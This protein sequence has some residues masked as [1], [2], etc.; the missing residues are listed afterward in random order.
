M[1]KKGVKMQEKNVQGKKKQEK[2]VQ[3]NRSQENRIQGKRVQEGKKQGSP[4]RENKRPESRAVKGVKPE[5][6]QRSEQKQRTEQKQRSEQK[7]KAA[8]FGK[9]VLKQQSGQNVEK[10][11]KNAKKSMCPVMR[12][13]GGCQMLDMPYAEQ[14][15]T[16]RK[17]LETLLKG[18]CPV[19]DMIG[20]EDPFYYR[21][22]VHAVFDRDRRGNI[23]SGI[24]QEN[25][26][27]VVPVE[28]CMIEDQKADEII[29]TIRGM[30]KSFKIRTFDE[31]TGYGLLRHVLIRRGF[32][33]GEI[34]VVLVT[35]SPVFPS[36]NNFVKALREK[37]PEITT[38][39]QNI[40]GRGTSMVLGEKEHV[41]YG[42]G[43]IV[44]TLCGCSF[45]ISS[46]SF[47]Q[48]NPVQTE[49]LYTKAL[50]LAGLTG[51]ET[52]VDA[53]CGIG[54]IGIIASKKAQNVI[55][56]E[57][58]QDAVRDAINNAKMNQISNIR[59]FCN[60]AGRFLVNMA[61]AGEKA[62][63]VIMDP[64]RSGST[65]EFMDSIAKMGAKKVVYVSCNP[66]TLA[67]DLV[68]MKKLGYKAKEAVGFDMFPATEHVETV[69]LL[70]HKKPDG[71]INVKVQFGEGEGKVPL[72]NIAKR[73]ESYKPKERVT[74][75]MIKEYIEAKYGFKV[76]TAYIAEVKRD[77]GLPMYDA[78]NAVEELKQPRKHPTAEKVEAIK[79][80]LKHFEVI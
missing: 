30:L 50:E 46:R 40:N 42:K 79:D 19:K 53:Y 44:D 38:I 78:P 74:Y 45:R 61:E 32:E 34:M 4:K 8:K 56:V 22:K 67:R 1:N 51:K 31:D 65:E 75:K 36:K 58:N 16:K 68:Y 60:D 62:D 70:S 59:F 12:Q 39:V 15:K 43:Y 18:I 5:Q 80:A 64:P 49:K 17:R 69:V 23:I 37:H 72:D 25:T 55:G 10:G 54:T 20:M 47:Y 28:K 24:Y 41:L 52:V 66:E 6:K 57:L 48:V 9:P 29:G 2:K 77:L 33:S 26:H 73:A 35:A 71:H 3:G 21:N 76:H 27:N 14:L 11:K 13:C 7:Q 63:V